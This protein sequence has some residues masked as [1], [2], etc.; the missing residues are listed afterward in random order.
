MGFLCLVRGCIALEFDLASFDLHCFLRL[1]HALCC[2]SWQCLAY[3]AFSVKHPRKRN[4]N[5]PH[6][7]ITCQVKDVNA[8]MSHVHGG[9]TVMYGLVVFPNNCVLQLWHQ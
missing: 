6:S 4:N 5:P 9:L 8:H 3:V 2:R 1:P 7:C